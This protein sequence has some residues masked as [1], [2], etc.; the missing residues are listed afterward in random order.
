MGRRQ[1][2]QHSQAVTISAGLTWL[3]VEESCTHVVPS[4]QLEGPFQFMSPPHCAH[5]SAGLL[6]SCSS[7]GAG[8]PASSMG[9]AGSGACA[10]A[11]AGCWSAGSAGCSSV[12]C[13]AESVI[14]LLQSEERGVRALQQSA[15]DGVH[16]RR[17]RRHVADCDAALLLCIG[18]GRKRAQGEQEEA[19]DHSTRRC[20]GCA[21]TDGRREVSLHVPIALDTNAAPSQMRVARPRRP[22]QRSSLRLIDR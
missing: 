14:T 5:G 19:C 10:G 16:G 13:H 22:L 20:H 3:K 15:T 17:C 9:S 11:S 18:D 21:R 7:A 1:R 8:A 2:F 4:T 6:A 12:R